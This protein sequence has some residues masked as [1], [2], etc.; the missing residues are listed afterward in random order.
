MTDQP[1][2][3]YDWQQADI[4]KISANLSEE[5]GALVVSAPGAGKTIVAVE[6]LRRLRPNVTLIVAPPSTHDNAWAR[7]IRRQGDLPLPRQLIGD[8][9]GRAAWEDL[10]WGK[11]GVYITSAQWFA[12]QDW[13]NIDIDMVIFD[14][15]HMVAKYGNVSQKKLIGHGKKK[16]LHAK[17]RIALSGTPFRNNFENAWTIARWVEPRKMQKDFWIWRIQDCLG[18]YDHF[19]PQ[20]LR[21]TGEREPGKLVGELTCFIAHYQ[22]ERCCDFH[23]DG[24]LA[25]LAPPIMVDR[26][27]LMTKDQEAFYRS[28]EQ[29]YIAYLTTPDETGRVPVVAELPIT[30]RGMLRFCALGLPA[31]NE[32]E[33]RLYFTEDCV[34]PKLDAVIEDLTMLDG[35]RALIMTHS[36][37]FAEVTVPRLQQAGFRVALWRGGV[38]QT[39][40][41]E[42]LS[43]FQNGE[44][45]AIVGVISAMGTG[46]DGLQ[47]AAY[48]VMWLSADDDASNNTQGIGRLDRLGQTHQ[49]TMFV[50]RMLKTFDVGHL[51]KQIET[52]LKLNQSLKASTK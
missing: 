33:E 18:T 16:G 32:A 6:V 52:Q 35:K 34:S 17:Y 48:N 26:D 7:T 3:P 45:D 20:N 37:Q 2:V 14:E 50:Y 38:S 11:P 9:K 24:F 30:A 19:A 1:L 44:L 8:R 42:I 31:F 5:V 10:R 12:R 13:G 40:R 43:Q 22:R 51:P 21:V 28:M 23:P 27:L 39:R 49:V 29:H 25:H 4:D 47:E 41:T 46:T 15:I 36:A